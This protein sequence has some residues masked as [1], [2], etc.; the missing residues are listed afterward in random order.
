MRV[1]GVLGLGT[2]HYRYFLYFF[3]ELRAKATTVCSEITTY[4]DSCHMN[5]LFY[6]EPAPYRLR[7]GCLKG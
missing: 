1:M 7:C 6:A 4:I 3:H 5:L 2:T